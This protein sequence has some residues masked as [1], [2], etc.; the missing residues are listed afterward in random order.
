MLENGCLSV[1][2]VTETEGKGD[3]CQ[4]LLL[5]RENNELAQSERLEAERLFKEINC[6]TEKD[7]QSCKTSRGRVPSV[8]NCS[9]K[10]SKCQPDLLPPTSI[11]NLTWTGSNPV[12]AEARL[13]HLLMSLEEKRRLE[14]GQSLGRR[15]SPVRQQNRTGLVAACSFKGRDCLDSRSWSSFTHPEYGNCFT[16]NSDLEQGNDQGG[17]NEYTLH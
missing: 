1:L 6:T 16:F 17:H 15:Y 2:R 7:C 9:K 12:H 3:W 10:S 8:P 11:S 5:N 4:S 14:V 13:V